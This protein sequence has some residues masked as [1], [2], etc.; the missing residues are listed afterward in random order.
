M[1]DKRKGLLIHKNTNLRIRYWI[2]FF[3]ELHNSVKIV[4]VYLGLGPGT[5]DLKLYVH[6]IVWRFIDAKRFC[7]QNSTLLARIYNN[8]LVLWSELGYKTSTIQ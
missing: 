8:E 5:H 3:Q 1:Y 4:V 6:R 7:F 2:S